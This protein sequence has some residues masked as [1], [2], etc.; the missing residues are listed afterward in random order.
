MKRDQDEAVSWMTIKVVLAAAALGCLF[1]VG[2]SA[3]FEKAIQSL[4]LRRFDTP[5]ISAVEAKSLQKPSTGGDLPK[6]AVTTV[7]ADV[8]GQNLAGHLAGTWDSD[9]K[10][11]SSIAKSPSKNYWWVG[12]TWGQIHDTGRLDLMA[13]NGCRIS[14]LLT[15][16]G[17]SGITGQA[18]FTNCADA[19]FNRT[20]NLTVDDRRLPAVRIH[21]NAAQNGGGNGLL[22]QWFM[23]GVF[24]RYK[25]GI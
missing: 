25:P 3:W 4:L 23:E 1:W 20:Y 9:S 12:Q 6:V 17:L 21:F 15:R 22:D 19:S 24:T 10:F 7:A 5:G 13:K 11:S 14:G 18:S 16:R 8:A 2:S